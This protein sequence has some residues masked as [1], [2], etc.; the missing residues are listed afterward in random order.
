MFLNNNA[1]LGNLNF[2]L[3][4][5]GSVI[6]ILQYCKD[7]MKSCMKESVYSSAWHESAFNYFYL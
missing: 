2:L 1:Q 3:L 7:E 5:N 4:W 6:N